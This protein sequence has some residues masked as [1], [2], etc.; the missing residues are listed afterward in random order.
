MRG[1][2]GG[3]LY[4]LV[5]GLPVAPGLYRMRSVY[6]AVDLDE[7]AGCKD[8]HDFVALLRKKAQGVIDNLR[9]VADLDD[10]A[11]LAE[12]IERLQAGEKVRMP[13]GGTMRE[14]PGPAG[15]L[16]NE[17]PPD[18]LAQAAADATP[19][20]KSDEEVPGAVACDHS[21]GSHRGRC[22]KCDARTDEPEK[23]VSSK[24]LRKTVPRETP[25]S[26]PVVERHEDGHVEIKGVP[27]ARVPAVMPEATAAEK[28]REMEIDLGPAPAKP[29]VDPFADEE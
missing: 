8:L 4:R 24:G 6:I 27:M 12:K 17:L 29:P 25:A 28:A 2:I 20:K 26:V 16:L 3:A 18:D 5:G 1:P 21:A 7:I 23:A 13:R 15:Q 19:E 11:H 14:A 9:T 22:L 10:Y